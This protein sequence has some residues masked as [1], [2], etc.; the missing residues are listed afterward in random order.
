MNAHRDGTKPPDGSQTTRSKKIYHRPV[1]HVYGN[2]RAI[3]TAVGLSGLA[4]GG[5]G[6]MMTRTSP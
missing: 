6:M 4:D 3:T 5:V 1:I 2:I